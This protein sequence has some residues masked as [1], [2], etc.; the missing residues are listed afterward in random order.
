MKKKT[1]AAVLIAVGLMMT[2]CGGENT[3]VSS[4][5]Q[6]PAPISMG[7]KDNT[8]TSGTNSSS[9]AEESK[10][11]KEEEVAPEHSYRSELTNEWIDED[12][13]DQRPIAVMVDNEKTALP[14]Y[15]LTE[16]DVVYEIMNSTLNDRITR[17][18]VLVKDWES[19]TQLGSIRSVRPTNF[20]LAAEWNAV[21]CHDG[22]PFFIDTWVA[23]DYTNNFSGGFA[24]FSNGKATEF[25]EYI[26]Y[27]KYTNSNK[28]KTYDGLKQRFA[29][30]KY[31]TTYN[32]YYEGPHFQFAADE[33]T[34]S[35]RSDADTATVV[36]LPFPHNKSTL[37]Y[38]E[39]TGTYDYYEYGAAHLDPLHDSAQ[40]TFKNVILQNT[41]FSELGEGYLIYNAIDSGRDGYYITN[42]QAIEVTWTKSG[43]SD[44]TVYYDKKTGKEIELNTGKTYI[45]LIPS[46]SW[47]NLVIK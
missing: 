8:T 40:L 32:Q 6:T 11:T 34:F 47:S 31:T 16:A 18:M 42:G 26:T 1:L 36:E 25:T 45:S 9:A 44:I 43:E 2:G 12:L 3:P 21:L 13:K 27:D 39:S 5:I 22:G 30:S 20:M 4:P 14:H 15:G 35:D 24:R 38:N 37:K 28:G 7:E 46:D 33:Q 23:K 10:G 19:I 29:N 17:F 41:T